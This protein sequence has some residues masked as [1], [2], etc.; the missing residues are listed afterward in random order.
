[1]DGTKVA[2]LALLVSLIRYHQTST[3]TNYSGSAMSGH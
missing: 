3:G 1:V 2:S